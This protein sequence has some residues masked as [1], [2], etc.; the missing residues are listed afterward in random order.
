MLSRTD[1]YWL[2]GGARTADLVIDRHLP[3]PCHPHGMDLDEMTLEEVQPLLWLLA[4]WEREGTGV[5]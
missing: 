1:G 3:P 5:D 2:P 4:E